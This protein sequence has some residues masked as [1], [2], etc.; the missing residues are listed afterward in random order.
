MFRYI[1]EDHIKPPVVLLLLCLFMLLPPPPPLLTL[2]SVSHTDV[3]SSSDGLP[4]THIHL[5]DSTWSDVH[6]PVKAQSIS[7][8]YRAASP[9]Q[10][11]VRRPAQRQMDRIFNF[12]LI[13]ED[14]FWFRHERRPAHVLQGDHRGADPCYWIYFLINILTSSH[15]S[16]H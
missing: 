5:S 3:S 16:P 4:Q 9:E 11:R 15:V 6:S 14:E 2:L 13:S 8:G 7:A 12:I 10:H 1:E